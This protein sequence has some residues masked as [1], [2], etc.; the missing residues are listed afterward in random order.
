[1]QCCSEICNISEDRAGL[2]LSIID[3]LHEQP[4]V[5]FALVGVVQAKGLQDLVKH[6]AGFQ[7]GRY[8]LAIPLPCV[9]LRQGTTTQFAV[10][11]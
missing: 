10:E 4:V 2:K 11:L 7:P 3:R 8:R 6:L 5:T 9:G 1:M